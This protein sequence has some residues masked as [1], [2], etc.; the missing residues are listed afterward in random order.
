M[1]VVNV[2]YILSNESGRRGTH[3]STLYATRSKHDHDQSLVLVY[4]TAV[5]T[6]ANFDA[7]PS[8]YLL[9]RLAQVD[10]RVSALLSGLCEREVLPKCQSC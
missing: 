1:A 5:D 4:K 6:L 9:L 7:F 2:K 3:G 10:S 8:V